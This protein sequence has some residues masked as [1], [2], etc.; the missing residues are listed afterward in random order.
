MSASLQV[1]HRGMCDKTDSKTKRLKNL[2]STVTTSK[3][4]ILWHLLIASGHFKISIS[5]FND[6]CKHNRRYH[7]LPRFSYHFFV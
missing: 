7:A 3:K 5:Q 2:N 1:M 6:V 4:F